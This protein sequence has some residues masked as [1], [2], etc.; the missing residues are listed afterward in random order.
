LN[1]PAGLVTPN[2]VPGQT[3]GFDA[4]LSCTCV[5]AAGVRAAIGGS[6]VPSNIIYD[7]Y[8]LDT[9]AIKGQANS[10][11][12]YNPVGAVSPTTATAGLVIRIHG[13]LTVQT[14][15]TLAI[16]FGQNTANATASVLMRGSWFKVWMM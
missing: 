16:I 7:G 11:A 10:A 8:L 4:Y 3:Y 5:A 6:V 13:S 14:A 15:G 9:N 1:A 2:L 12:M